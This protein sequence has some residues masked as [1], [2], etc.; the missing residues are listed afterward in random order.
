M[1]NK[2]VS[3]CT[4]LGFTVFTILLGLTFMFEGM[5]ESFSNTKIIN[6]N[7]K[8]FIFLREMFTKHVSLRKALGSIAP[9]V[10]IN[11]LIKF[12]DASV[13]LINRKV[14]NVFSA[15]TKGKWTKSR[16]GF[17]VCDCWNVQPKQS[18]LTI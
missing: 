5:S 8:F 9:T 10:L 15:Y 2:R 16:K 17:D 7:W 1:L 14:I 4:V 13:S 3:L 6:I 12:K 11:F 18:L